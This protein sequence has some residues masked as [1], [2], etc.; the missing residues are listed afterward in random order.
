MFKRKMIV[1]LLVFTILVVLPTTTYA[2]EVVELSDGT[3]MTEADKCH[4]DFLN[5][6]RGKDITFYEVISL[7]FP[8]LLPYISDYEL[9]SMKST[10]MEW[11]DHSI[12]YDADIKP[13]AGVYNTWITSQIGSSGQSVSF[14]ST[15]QHTYNLLAFR[16]PSSTVISSLIFEDDNIVKSFAVTGTNSS[17][18]TTGTRYYDNAQ[19][20]YYMTMGYHHWTYP[21][22]AIPASDGGHSFSLDGKWYKH[23]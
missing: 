16:M 18:V 13:E 6:I 23:N 20:G 19:S 3:Y 12:P 4:L 5:E 17:L 2:N 8:E 7:V 11:Q 21:P 22:G 14:K 15:S 1:L 10:P 9:A